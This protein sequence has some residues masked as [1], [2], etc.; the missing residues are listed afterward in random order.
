MEQDPRALAAAA[1]D[2]ASRRLG[3]ACA[4]LLADVKA[5]AVAVDR[6]LQGWELEDAVLYVVHLALGRDRRAAD[7]F[8]AF[9]LLEMERSARSMIAPHLHRYL[10]SDDLVQSVLGNLWPEMT[11]LRF[12]TRRQFLALLNQRLRWKISD[13]SRRLSAEKVRADQRLELPPEDLAVP[14]AGPSPSTL[15]AQWEDKERLILFL[16]RLPE[17]E[18]ELM[19]LYLRGEKV[20]VIA[21]Q[22][23]RSESSTYKTVRH[24]MDRF[25]AAFRAE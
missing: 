8:L 2:F 6:I 21:R 17:G 1:Q 12:E 10:D 18:R 13:R 11:A 7:E 14:Q 15:A 20:A 5:Q 9:F 19:R 22:L 23:G 4:A 3:P 24:V 16:S 25:K